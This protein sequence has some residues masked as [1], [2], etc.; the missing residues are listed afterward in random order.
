MTAHEIELAVRRLSNDQDPWEHTLDNGAVV[1]V[2]WMPQRHF[3][4][5]YLVWVS[6][7]RARH[8]WSS[9]KLTAMTPKT[10]STKARSLISKY[11]TSPEP[12]KACLS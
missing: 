11:G 1:H 12:W 6:K 10:A 2:R 4:S 9:P 3:G 8:I 5:W 7:R